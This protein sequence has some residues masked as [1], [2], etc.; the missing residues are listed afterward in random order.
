M[1]LTRK[2]PE[3]VPS[4]PP[5]QLTLTVELLPGLT[6]PLVAEKCSEPLSIA[7][8]EMLQ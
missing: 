2:L 8:C 1:P 7:D 5:D 3:P 6:L 4:L